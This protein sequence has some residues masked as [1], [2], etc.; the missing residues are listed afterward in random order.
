M[1]PGTAADLRGTAMTDVGVLD[2]AAAILR[3]L[4]SSSMTAGEVC[5]AVDLSRSTG[6]RLLAALSTHGFIVRTATGHYILGPFPRRDALAEV[7]AVLTGLRDQTEESAQL[8]ML[9]GDRRA[10]VVSIDSKHDLRVSKSPGTALPL[11]DGGSGAHAL[12]AAGS[13]SELFI[14]RGGRKAG[15]G[16]SAIAFDVDHGR[17]LAL[18]VS[19]PLARIPGQESRLFSALLSDAVQLLMRIVPESGASD[20]LSDIA[21][22]AR[23]ER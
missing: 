3:L 21:A 14:T 2:K 7:A 22:G 18:C 13:P 8:W 16:S 11:R 9:H 17:R 19:Y 12:L 5:E 4:M 20:S 6:Y 23:L 10:C 15:G 1:K